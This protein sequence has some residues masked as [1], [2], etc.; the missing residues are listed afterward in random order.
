[1]VHKEFE[2]GR[3][4]WIIPEDK[5][6]TDKVRATA[7]QKKCP[8]ITVGI[9]PTLEGKVDKIPCLYEE[10]DQE[11]SLPAIDWSQEVEAIKKRLDD[12]EK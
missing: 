11:P 9:P 2:M 7:K 8:E 10:P 1:M 3:R 6:V 5:V 4:I 12:L